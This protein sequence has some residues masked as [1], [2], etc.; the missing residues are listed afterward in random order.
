MDWPHGCE[1]GQAIETNLNSGFGKNGGLVD[2]TELVT[3]LADRT[4]QNT[5][6]L[7][8]RY[9]SDYEWWNDYDFIVRYIVGSF[10][11]RYEDLSADSLKSILEFVGVGPIDQEVL[12]QVVEQYSE[13]GTHHF[14]QVEQ[15]ALVQDWFTCKL[16]FTEIMSQKNAFERLEEIALQLRQEIDDL[17]DSFLN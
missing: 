8:E 11:N 5:I 14:T 4:G 1:I 12:E 9:D 3:R 2:I 10:V 7:L 6:K 13:D 17:K 16:Q 15:M